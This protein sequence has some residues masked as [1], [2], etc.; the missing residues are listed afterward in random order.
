VRPDNDSDVLA[1]A[2]L[3]ERFTCAIARPPIYGVQFHPEKSSAAGLRVLAN[4]A[5]ICAAV[6]A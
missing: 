3:G 6:P 1:T 4:F 2:R 5:G